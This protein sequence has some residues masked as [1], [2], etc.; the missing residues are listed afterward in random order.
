K[1]HQEGLTLKQAAVALGYLTGE[2]F[3]RHIRPERMVSPQLGE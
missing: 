2:E 3:D 1:A